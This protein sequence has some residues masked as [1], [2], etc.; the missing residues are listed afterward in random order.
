MKVF[1]VAVAAF[2]MAGAKEAATAEYAGDVVKAPVSATKAI[3]RPKNYEGAL[4]VFPDD[5]EAAP[6]GAEGAVVET[7]K[8]F[9]YARAKESLAFLK[10]LWN[11]QKRLQEGFLQGSTLGEYDLDNHNPYR[12]QGDK[13]K[14]LPE[15]AMITWRLDKR[16][17]VALSL[18]P[19][20]SLVLGGANHLN[21]LA[22]YADYMQYS[23]AR[24]KLD[25]LEAEGIRSG[26]EYEELERMR[27]ESKEAVVQYL[28][29]PPAD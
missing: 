25:L 24:L 19:W 26:A 8:L 4:I 28:K 27:R 16:A 11:D 14:S 13:A 21:F 23:A 29:I 12:F 9:T 2:A 7:E 10:R 22:A 5:A 1:I 17:F 6:S 20:D 18:P 15:D 3:S